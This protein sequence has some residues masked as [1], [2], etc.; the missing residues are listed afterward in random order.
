MISFRSQSEELEGTQAAG[1]VPAEVTPGAGV[2]GVPGAAEHADDQVAGGGEQARRGAGQDP[3]GVF[4]VSC[5][6]AVVQA[7]LDA[8][9]VPVMG[10]Q[11]GRAGLA[12]GQA[13]DPGDC[14]ARHFRAR[15]A[16]AGEQGLPG[17]LAAAGSGGAD[18]DVARRPGAG[19][20]VTLDQ[21]HL[22]GT[23]PAG[24]DRLGGGGGA[25]DAD[26]V[27]AVA[28][29]VSDVLRGE[30]TPSRRSRSGFPGR[31]GCPWR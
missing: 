23:G 31:P 2:V 28:G 8:P 29:L 9:V 15:L 13:G 6:A 30:R 17:V 21:E 27:A 4:A 22:P 10:E 1:A 25:D 14:L 7:V 3:A 18:A 12:G 16:G 20:P 11:A 26:V 24:L 5:V 19:V